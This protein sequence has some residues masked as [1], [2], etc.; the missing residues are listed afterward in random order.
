[1]GLSTALW[2]EYR[3]RVFFPDEK[4]DP[5]RPCGKRYDRKHEVR[6]SSTSEGRAGPKVR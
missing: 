6:R 1:M 2:F 4:D 3:L 5:H